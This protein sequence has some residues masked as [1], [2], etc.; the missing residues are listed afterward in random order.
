MSGIS[1]RIL[2]ETQK[3]NKEP[4]DGII[5]ERDTTNE[6]YFKVLANGPKDSP[7]EGGKFQLEIYLPEEYPM[8]PPKVIFKTKIYHPNIDFLGRI[9]LD[10]LKKEWSPALQIRTV[11]FSIMC[12]LSAPNTEDPLNEKVNEH[13]VKDEK[14]AKKTA[15]EWTKKYAV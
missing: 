7:Y 11:L 10:I 2:K 4:I 3:L 13:W 8:V 5:V 14:D 1:A 15:K 9:C 6:R 12:L